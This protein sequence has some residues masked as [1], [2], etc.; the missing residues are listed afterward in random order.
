MSDMKCPFCQQKLEED[1]IDVQLFG[2]ENQNCKHWINNDI[3]GSKE[4]W[5]EL[6]R[7]RKALE[8]NETCCSKWEKQAL[9]YKAELIRTKQILEIAIDKLKGIKTYYDNNYDD[10]YFV[11][12]HI[13]AQRLA[14]D[15]DDAIKVI[16][17]LEQ[18]DK[19]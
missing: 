9:D 12:W 3:I 11:N 17:A 15:A 10:P 18:K 13:I 2:C 14:N 6:I 4:L 7:T 16:T 8:Q 5:Q 19:Q 1:Y